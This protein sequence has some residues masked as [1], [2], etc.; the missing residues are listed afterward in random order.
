MLVYKLH[1]FDAARGVKELGI[2]AVNKKENLGDALFFHGHIGRDA[3]VVH[4]EKLTVVVSKGKKLLL[5]K[6]NEKSI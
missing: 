1:S 4:G 3:L 6:I 2:F 5:D